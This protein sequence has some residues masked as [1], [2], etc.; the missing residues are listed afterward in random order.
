[1]ETEIS[2]AEKGSMGNDDEEIILLSAG[3]ISPGKS[4]GHRIDMSLRTDITTRP[5]LELRVT[6][7]EDTNEPSRLS[8]AAVDDL[9]RSLREMKTRMREENQQLHR[10]TAD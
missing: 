1:L 6:G 5:V 9:I 4:H 8:M 2:N 7:Y 3:A 10:A